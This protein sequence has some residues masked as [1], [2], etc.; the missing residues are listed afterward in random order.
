MG[1]AGVGGEEGLFLLAQPECNRVHVKDMLKRELMLRCEP[2]VEGEQVVTFIFL[3]L[4]FII[5][6]F[7]NENRTSAGRLNMAACS[8]APCGSLHEFR[9]RPVFPLGPTGRAGS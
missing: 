5:K 8:C 1:C 2:I 7:L 4:V 9:E 6:S 3:L